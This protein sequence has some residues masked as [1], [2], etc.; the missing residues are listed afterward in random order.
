[1]KAKRVV[2]FAAL[3][4]GTGWYAAA[5][6]AL[7]DRNGRMTSMFYSGEELALRGRVQ[8]LSRDG[9]R[10]AEP[11]A[12][13]RGGRSGGQN[14][15]TTESGTARVRQNVTEEGGRTWIDLEVTADADLDIPGVSY[16][17]DLPRAEFLGGQATIQKTAG[18]SVVTLPP[19]RPPVRD[20]YTGEGS[21]ISFTGARDLRLDITLD[22]PRAIAL[23]DRWDRFG[24]VFTAAIQMHPGKLAASQTASM[25]IGLSLRGQPDT[26]P[27]KLR[28]DTA[29]R[30]YHF[31]GAGG[32]Y[33][34]N[35]ESPVSRYTLDHLNVA[36]GRTEMSL[37][38]WEP[39][40][41][42]AAPA[43]IAYFQQREQAYPR[44]RLEMQ[45]GKQLQDKG[46]PYVVS[47]WAIPEWAY[48]DPGPAPQRRGRRH[49]APDKIGAL[50]R[51]IGSY[52]Q[53]AK[54]QYGA[55]PDLF[56][57]NEANLGVDV[58]LTPEEHRDMIKRLG[59]HFEELG[60][61]TRLLLGDATGPRNTHEWALAAANDPEAMRYLKAVGFHS[62]GGGT[63]EH[64]KAWGDL[65]EW[66]QLPL[67]VTEL[68]VDASAYMGGMYDSFSYGMRE[69]RMYQELLLY[70]R[71]QGT[72]QWEFTADYGIVRTLRHDDGTAELVPTSRF[73]L[74]KHFT[75]LTPHN[76]DALATNSDNDKVLMTAFTAGRD[77]QRVY[78]IHVANMAATRQVT[79]EGLPDLEFRAVRTSEPRNFEELQPVRPQ[80]GTIRLDLAAR[81]LLTLTTMP[82]Q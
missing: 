16:T 15:I 28:L 68:G 24:R 81:S 58:T 67:L 69:V 62:W 52:L 77:D 75:D 46:I 23:G 21:G 31:A 55:E 78:T 10:T 48:T 51:S 80:G 59:A 71:P 82:R 60:L 63:P 49:L 22:H 47:I 64:Y 54:Q 45:M 4:A 61:K 74:V 5:E 56:S 41:H 1:M 50:V 44:L 37:S 65:A 17:M 6:N 66:L 39:D 40:E 20:F 26:T 76:A 38:Y 34:F 19:Y 30:R 11:V 79:I 72:Q 12:P 57:F 42:S 18:Q 8:I 29:T 36:W 7:F 35:I 70:A 32:N 9:T 13:S 14:V 53:Y 73:W 33:C 25:R 27:A 2:T 3:I 43:G